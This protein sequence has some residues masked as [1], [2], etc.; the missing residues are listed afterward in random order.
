METELLKTLAQ[1]VGIGG[2]A[3]GVLLLVY[4]ELRPPIGPPRPKPSATG[5]QG[6]HLRIEWMPLHG[7]PPRSSRVSDSTAEPR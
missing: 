6:K 4:R 5:G 3:L 1:A 7:C 2:A